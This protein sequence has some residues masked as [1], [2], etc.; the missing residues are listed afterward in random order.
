MATY[1]EIMA[2]AR[3][4]D[5]QGDEGAARRLVQMAQAI[6]K[7]S[8]REQSMNGVNEGIAGILGAPVD[9]ATM[10]LNAGSQAINAIAGTEIP[11]IEN[12]VGGSNTFRQPMEAAGAITDQQPQTTAQRYARSI[13]RET[14]AMS[15]PGLGLLAK[16]AQPARVGLLELASALGAGVGSQVARDEFPDNQIAESVG[17]LLGGLAPSAVSRTARPGPQ[18]PDMDTLREQQEQAYGVVEESQARVT[19][20]SSARLSEGLRQR[21]AEEGVPEFLPTPVR[22]VSSKIDALPDDALISDIEDLRRRV[23]NDVAGSTDRQTS[24]IGVGLK[25]KIDDYLR[26]L[27]PAE[28]TAAD[29]QEVV[30]ALERGREVTQRIRKSEALGGETGA[31]T[32]AIRRAATSGTGGNEVNAIKQNIR[33]ILDSP[34]KRRGFTSDEIEL[35]EQIVEGTGTENLLRHV[36]RMS[37]T[38]GALPA[39]AGLGATGTTMGVGLGPVGMVPSLLGLGAQT[40]LEGMSRRRVGLLD[41][42]VRNGAP[43]APKVMEDYERR[44]ILGLLTSQTASDGDAAPQ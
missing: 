17:G 7:T 22:S 14:G 3:R 42:L 18:A 21:L 30:G 25:D 16:A 40:T 4:A 32:R 15:V 28:V 12:P 39:M 24:R 35:M 13:G 8:L 27:E 5:A 26:S 19:P 29:P 10:G 37:P 44:A 38:S 2:A 9:I 6:P 34:R 36:G 33:A 20:E 1:E 43:L 31:V 41:E 23:G 11:R